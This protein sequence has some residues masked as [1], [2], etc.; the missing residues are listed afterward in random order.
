MHSYGSYILGS[1]ISAWKTLGDH[2]LLASN[3]EP[4]ILDL[5]NQAIF[6][7]LQSG[8]LQFRK[9]QPRVMNFGFC[10]P[11]ICMGIHNLGTCN[12]GSHNLKAQMLDLVDHVFTWRLQPGRLQ[13]KKLQ[14][15]HNYFRF[16]EP[17][18]CLE[19]QLLY[20]TMWAPQNLEPT[21]SWVTVSSHGFWI[22]PTI[23]VYRS[24]TLRSYNLGRYNL[25]LRR[26][27]HMDTLVNDCTNVS[28]KI[29]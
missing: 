5:L 23:H 7:K 2:R 3:F 16:C 29:D 25:G 13:S 24:Y 21:S 17:F 27:M 11:L 10:Q 22:S 1:Y 26:M 19:T 6:R 18:F 20:I 15:R 9:L 4:R 12:F 14:F 28:A 8:K